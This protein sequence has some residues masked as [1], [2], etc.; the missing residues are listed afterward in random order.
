M[1]YRATDTMGGFIG[2]C[3]VEVVMQDEVLSNAKAFAIPV[4]YSCTSGPGFLSRVRGGPPIL[5]LGSGRGRHMIAGDTLSFSEGRMRVSLGEVILPELILPDSAPKAETLA[6]FLAQHP[7]A[8]QWEIW[9]A[10]FAAGG[11]LVHTLLT[12]DSE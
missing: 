5:Y 4:P 6:S 8:P 10:A 11:R 9:D 12:G 1:W 7:H 3:A 2:D